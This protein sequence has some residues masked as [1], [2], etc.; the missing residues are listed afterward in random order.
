MI[1]NDYLPILLLMGLGLFMAGFFTVVGIL[2]GPKRHNAVKD[3]PFECG[4]PSQ[5][6][7]GQ[8][9]NVKFYMTALAFL[10]FDVEVVFLYPWAVKFRELGWHGFITGGIFI[11]FLTLGLIY[12]WKK[13]GLEWE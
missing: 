12:E 4:F 1:A 11:A 3:Q 10:I 2:L 13:G 5:G 6:T 8:R 7:E 9:Y